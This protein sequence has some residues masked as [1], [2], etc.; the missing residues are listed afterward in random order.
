MSRMRNQFCAMLLATA[1]LVAGCAGTAKAPPPATN[2][3]GVNT[4]PVTV[5]DYAPTKH[6]GDG[7]LAPPQ[8][9]DKP[10]GWLRPGILVQ[11]GLCEGAAPLESFFMYFT[12]SGSV[13]EATARSALHVEGASPERVEVFTGGQATSIY[14][15]LPAGKKGDRL[16]VRMTGTVAADGTRVDLGFHLWRAES[17]HM[18]AEIK[19]AGGDWQPVTP[20][21]TLPKG[22]LSLRFHL[23]GKLSRDQLAEDVRRNFAPGKDD[24]APIPLEVTPE[25]ENALVATLPAP[26]PRVQVYL[27]GGRGEFGLD[28]HPLYFTVYTGEPPQ[29]VSF[30]PATGR[31]S[32]LGDAPVDVWE[33]HSSPDFKWVLI[34]AIK[35]DSQYDR[36]LW[37]VDTQAGAAHKTSLTPS[38][39]SNPY[40]WRGGQLVVPAGKVQTLDLASRTVTTAPSAG[41]LWT[42]ASPDQRYLVGFSQYTAQEDPKTWLAPTTVVIHDLETHREHVFKDLVHTVVHHSESGPTMAAVWSDDGKTVYVAD[43]QRTSM[44]ANPTTRWLAIE[45][46]TGRVAEFGGPAAKLETPPTPT[47]GPTGW[48]FEQHDAWGAIVLHGPK[49]E[50][51]EAGQGRVLGWR[52]DGQLLIVRWA[53]AHYARWPGV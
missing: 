5:V 37:L 19:P 42:S 53:N 51:R 46:A 11:N 48:R 26:P 35:G 15:Y 41:G 32:T 25:G 39:G 2:P 45:V 16:T 34:D 4:P 21:A 20:G 38:W 43:L 52:P 22:P 28:A 23:Y 40:V 44:Q 18:T 13:D 36:D 3:G 12:L 17:P 14:V 1:F 50:T 33:A 27:S 6:L 9:Q 31:V 24:P 10:T 49:G 7:C 8:P 30:D 29:L 47:P